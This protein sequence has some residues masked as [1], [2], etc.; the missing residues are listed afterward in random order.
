MALIGLLVLVLGPAGRSFGQAETMGSQGAPGQG[1]ERPTAALK[2]CLSN[3]EL[4]SATELDLS[5]SYVERLD[6]ALVLCYQAG[7]ENPDIPEVWKR[8]GA[9][10]ESKSFF[11][12]DIKERFDLLAEAAGHFSHSARLEFEKSNWEFLESE[13]GEKKVLLTDPFLADLIWLGRL[14]R[15]EV[16]MAEIFQRHAA[17][18]MDPSHRPEFWRE[19]ALFI[20]AKGDWLKQDQELNE[21]RED[22]KNLWST[23]PQEVPWRSMV[24]KF[25]PQKIKK[26][27]VME[28]WA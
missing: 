15:D 5:H 11:L 1:Q 23:M 3:Q 28:A 2:T 6:K 24:D 20:Q 10:A 14:R 19:R 8:L 21:A 4:L 12:T 7:Y 26:V 22:F 13:P 18:N 17:E 16:T 9:L 27:E 25:G